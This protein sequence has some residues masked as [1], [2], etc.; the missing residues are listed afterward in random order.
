MSET[1]DGAPAPLLR[2]LLPSLAGAFVFLAPVATDSAFTIPFS[3]VTDAITA[4]IASFHEALLVGVLVFGAVGALLWPVLGRSAAEDS[5]LRPLFDVHWIW[6]FLRTLGAIFA[7]MV[8]F[9]IG[10]SAW[11]CW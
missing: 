11:R 10:T 7:V 6:T 9:E 1:T 3:L 5:V 8:F 4:V 2:F